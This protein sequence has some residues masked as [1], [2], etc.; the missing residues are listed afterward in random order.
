ME[1]RANYHIEVCVKPF[2]GG[3]LRRD[4]D[5]K[6]TTREI[7]VETA[8]HYLRTETKEKFGTI[9]GEYNVNLCYEI[10]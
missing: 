2:C 10:N 4:Y 1:K 8:Y 7:A 3:Y 5:I 6:H 9:D